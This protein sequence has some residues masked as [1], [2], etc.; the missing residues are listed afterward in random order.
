MAE[1]NLEFQKVAHDGVRKRLS[2]KMYCLHS[3]YYGSLRLTLH[4]IILKNCALILDYEKFSCSVENP[5]KVFSANMD[6]YESIV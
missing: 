6:K 1:G 4:R 5:F 3:N 2:D